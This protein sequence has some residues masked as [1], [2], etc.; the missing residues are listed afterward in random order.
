MGVALG[1][2]MLALSTQLSTSLCMVVGCAWGG[3]EKGGMHSS[4]T[5]GAKMGIGKNMKCKCS[6]CAALSAQLST[7]LGSLFSQLARQLK[8]MSGKYGLALAT[9]I[10]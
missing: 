5:V 2:G 3:P 9:C 1:A 7:K 4:P 10:R 6:K 8:Q